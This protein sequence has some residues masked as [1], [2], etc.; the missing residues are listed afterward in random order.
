MNEFECTKNIETC[1]VGV[2][3]CNLCGMRDCLFYEDLHYH[4][5]GCPGCGGA[6]REYEHPRL[7]NGEQDQVLQG[8]KAYTRFL[9]DNEIPLTGAELDAIIRGLVVICPDSTR[10][11]RPTQEM[12]FWACGDDTERL[13]LYTT[14]HREKAIQAHSEETGEVL[15]Y[16]VPYWEEMPRYHVQPPTFTDVLEHYYENYGSALPEDYGSGLSHPGHERLFAKAIA[17]AWEVLETTITE[18]VRSLAGPVYAWGN[19]ERIDL[20]DPNKETL[21]D[22]STRKRR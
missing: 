13:K 17:P 15:F 11:D 20:S 8:L 16:V 6:Y 22:E 18:F 4:H 10:W 2:G 14:L 12:P 19:D 21:F 5:D 1:Q 3:E 7:L 9:K